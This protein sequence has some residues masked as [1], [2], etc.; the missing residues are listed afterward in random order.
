MKNIKYKSIFQQF[1]VPVM[2]IVVLLAAI[3]ILEIRMVFTG[4]HEKQVEKQN[5]DTSVL[6]AKEVETFMELAYRLS[7]GLSVS[8]DIVSMKTDRQTPV[9]VE[10]AERNDFVELYYVQG[11][12]G[13]QT[14]RSSGEL[15][16]R[17]TRW[18]FQQMMETKQPFVSKS[19]YSVNTNMP[20]AS[21]F[22]P[23]EK[24]GEMAGVFATDIKLSSLQELIEE[25][26]SGGEGSY[27]FIID[28]EGV[29]AAH[30]DSVRMEE[31]YNYKN[32]T[33]TVS[34]KDKDGAAVLD[35]DG[36]VKTEEQP[37]EVS[38]GFKAAVDDVMAGNQGFCRAEDGEETLYISYAP[39]FLEGASDSWS[40]LTVQT[41][42]SAMAIRDRIVKLSMITGLVMLF[43]ALLLI[44]VLTKRIA[45]PIRYAGKMTERMA[46]GNFDGISGYRSKNE[47][48]AILDSLNGTAAAI[49]DMIEDITQQLNSIAKGDFTSVPKKEYTGAFAPLGLAIREIND[50]LNCLL[51]EINA[52]SSQVALGAQAVSNEAAGLAS[53]ALHQD[54]LVQ[55][56]EEAMEAMSAKIR[57]NEEKAAAGRSLSAEMTHDVSRNQMEMDK[58]MEAM[59]EISR[60]SEDISRVVKVI[61]D[62]SFQTN[63]LA[64]NA[65][66]EAARAGSSGKGFA[67]VA[68]EVRNL[69]T[70][71]ADATRQTAEMIEQTVAAVNKGAKEAQMAAAAL[72]Q[73]VDKTIRVDQYM[74]EIAQNSAE[75]RTSME[76][77]KENIDGIAEVV[78]G[79]SRSAQN[80]AAS[81]EELS[82]MSDTM[83]GLIKRF[84]LK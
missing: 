50:S 34:V 29:V 13:M 59:Q 77:V 73:V 15:A 41:E 40:V 68:E 51:A 46:Q 8:S 4:Y 69:A 58:L 61:D 27:S 74:E 31:L 66:V 30:P 48:G 65:A 39:I 47:I 11:M 71:S 3:I 84:R 49:R 14:G 28:G 44:F 26:A 38:D 79:S 64:L 12:D 55:S 78:A 45:A 82:S 20:C 2:L 54:Q 23:I 67:V 21:V 53:G 81:S 57:D 17:S 6:I 16:D 60:M 56:L 42:A 36:N 76:H 63:I 35:A 18:W 7:E 83:L 62:I 10:S 1:L 75:E 9:L 80:S 72:E 33:K 19:Y 24:D 52:S 22:L 43:L 32:L 70:K 37:I 25:A 5:L